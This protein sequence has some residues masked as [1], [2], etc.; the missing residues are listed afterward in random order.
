MRNGLDPA[1]VASVIGPLYADNLEIAE[2]LIRRHLQDVVGEL[3]G[4]STL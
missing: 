4:M 2:A 1:E 3:I